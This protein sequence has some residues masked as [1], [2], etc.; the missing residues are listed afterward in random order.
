[1]TDSNNPLFG[2]F[3][4]LDLLG[5]TTDT[6]NDL[7]SYF[8][9]ED[10]N[11]ASAV[12]LASLGSFESLDSIDTSISQA[13]SESAATPASI[14]PLDANVQI[15]QE[16][17][18]IQV[19]IAH[20]LQQQEQLRQQQQLLEEQRQKLQ[21]Q[22]DVKSASEPCGSPLLTLV[23]SPST[24]TIVPDVVGAIASVAT[25]TVPSSIPT[26][27]SATP[28]STAAT[29]TAQS[30]SKRLPFLSYQLRSP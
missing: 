29:A 8:F 5:S 14:S 4:E 30:K 2:D 6:N 16:H 17:H 13:S 20:N 28:I 22:S 23:N 18:D 9:S 3:L 12:D 26:T 7:F 19:L 25:T 24:T 15:K 21:P 1:M 11:G 10:M 27:T